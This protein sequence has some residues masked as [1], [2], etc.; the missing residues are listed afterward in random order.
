MEPLAPDSYAQFLADLKSR[1]QAAQLRA[2]IAV[3]RELVLLYWQIGRDILDR[4]QRESWGAKVIDRLAAD[5]KREFPEIPQEL[6]EVSDQ[7]IV[8]LAWRRRNLQSAE[9]GQPSGGA[10]NESLAR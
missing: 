8:G 7:R 2:S 4:Q 6:S 10:M 3:N 1:S 5:L 9:E